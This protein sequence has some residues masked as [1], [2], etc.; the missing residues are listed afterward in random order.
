VGSA[1]ERY[2]DELRGFLS[3]VGIPQLSAALGKD[4][5]DVPLDDP[6]EGLGRAGLDI[7]S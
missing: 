5:V 4:G 2:E 7:F 1:G 3:A 6:A